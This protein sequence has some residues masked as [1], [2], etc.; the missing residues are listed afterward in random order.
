VDEWGVGSYEETAQELMPA[1]AVAVGALGVVGGERVLDVA[2]GTGNAARVAHEAGARVTGI[3]TSSR[4]VGV[5][6]ERVPQ[7]TFLVGDAAE[8]PFDDGAFDAAVSVFGVIFARPAERAAAEIARVVGPGGT[9]AVTSWPARGPVFAAVMLM[10]QALARVRPPAPAGP[11]PVN[12]GDPE[13]L[14]ALLGPYGEVDVTEQQLPHDRGTPE[15]VFDRWERFH[16]MW[17]GARQELEPTGQWEP[18][19]ERSIAA[20]HHEDLAALV[21]SPYM[22]AVLRRR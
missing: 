14:A 8:L 10:R 7:G 11:P 5:A 2:C 12:W 21:A 19:R 16:P 17:I 6:R 13:V 18:L 1:A 9:V 15:Q 22:L 4:L 20:M 3:D